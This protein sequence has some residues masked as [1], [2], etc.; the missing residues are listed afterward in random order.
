MKRFDEPACEIGGDADIGFDGFVGREN[1]I[2]R[3]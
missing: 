2:N 1:E 3:P